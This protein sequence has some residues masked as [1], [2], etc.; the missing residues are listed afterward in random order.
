MPPS[1]LIMSKYASTPSNALA[2]E[3]PMGLVD[4]A[5]PPTLISVSVTPGASTDG[6]DPVGSPPPPP[7]SEP[8]S[9]PP[10]SSAG[11][12]SGPALGSAFPQAAA[13]ATT[14]TTAPVL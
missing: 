13:S 10:A 14:T 6:N 11:S 2:Y 3:P 12:S 8:P 1:A 9:E 5:T 4:D 7:S